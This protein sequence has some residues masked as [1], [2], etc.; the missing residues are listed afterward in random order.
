MEIA[1]EEN[2]ENV[3]KVKNVKNVRKMCIIVR[4]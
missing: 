4:C 1:D 2:I 3:G